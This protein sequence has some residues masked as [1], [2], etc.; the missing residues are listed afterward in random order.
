MDSP[1]KTAYQSVKQCKSDVLYLKMIYPNNRFALKLYARYLLEIK[2]DVVQYRKTLDSIALLQRGLK[3]NNDTVHD[4]GL[5][6][7]PLIPERLSDSELNI[8][9]GENESGVLDEI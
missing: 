8:K 1:I 2:S 9:T 6:S 3:I 4:L 7:F 5:E